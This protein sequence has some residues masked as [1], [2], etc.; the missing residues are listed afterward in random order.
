[1]LDLPA[2][3]GSDV[4]AQGVGDVHIDRTQPR[5]GFR[6]IDELVIPK[7][8]TANAAGISVKR[9][10]ERGMLLTPPCHLLHVAAQRF[11]DF[12]IGGAILDELLG[13]SDK[14]LV[15]SRTV[16]YLWRHSLGR[17]RFFLAGF[18]RLR[19]VNA[20]L[21][22]LAGRARHRPPPRLALLAASAATAP[23]P[24]R[25]SRLSMRRLGAN[26]R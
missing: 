22:G 4:A 13:R 15:P 2:M 24:V 12:L 17:V 1:M 8:G 25:R 21:H 18:L 3:Q 19:G 23:V 5:H 11:R 6:H 26:G 10:V 9:L 16:F 7:R 14:P 20:T